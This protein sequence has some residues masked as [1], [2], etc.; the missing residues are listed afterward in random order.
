MMPKS[1]WVSDVILGNVGIAVGVDVG[2]I[3][4]RYRRSSELVAERGVWEEP[5]DSLEPFLGAPV[6]SLEFFLLDN[7]LFSSSFFNLGTFRTPPGNIRSLI[8]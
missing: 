3:K 8:T 7:I 2:V 6:S 5:V 1:K 4:L